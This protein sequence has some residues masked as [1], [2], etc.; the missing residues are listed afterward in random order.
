M[1]T[2]AHRVEAARG[3]ALRQAQAQRVWLDHAMISRRRREVLAAIGERVAEAIRAGELPQAASLPDIAEH[4]EDLEALDADLAEADAQAREAAPRVAARWTGDAAQPR[5][6]FARRE[7][8][9]RVWRPYEAMAE[10]D[11]LGRAEAAEEGAEEAPGR[12]RGVGR[13]ARVAP[14]G[15]G[16]IAFGGAAKEPASPAA[17]L[18]PDVESDPLADVESDPL[19]DDED[20]LEAYMHSEDVP[21]FDRAERNVAA[22]NEAV[23]GAPANTR[24]HKET[25]KIR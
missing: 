10:A 9:L 20:D 17:A 14:R 25:I 5:A 24:D 18:G 2:T 7:G 22:E 6:P 3:A 13:R 11:E 23:D 16:G 21:G 8:D 15:G 19:A 4:L 12:E 1:R